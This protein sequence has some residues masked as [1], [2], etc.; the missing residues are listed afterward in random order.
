[1][2]RRFRHETRTWEYRIVEALNGKVSVFFGQ[3]PQER[4]KKGAPVDVFR[5]AKRNE[6]VVGTFDEELA[7]ATARGF[8]IEVDEAGLPLAQVD[9]L[10]LLLAKYFGPYARFEALRKLLTKAKQPQP[11]LELLLEQLRA[12]ESDMDEH[13]TPFPGRT[14]DM[15]AVHAYRRHY[16]ALR[17]KA[18]AGQRLS[19]DELR[20][21]YE[22]GA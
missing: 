22:V 13:D 5:D 19:A 18:S 1:M 21:E 11:V 14:P 2:R 9:E 3:D 17:L 16:E 20:F 12:I 7:K 8:S 4:P 10:R 15:G 6:G